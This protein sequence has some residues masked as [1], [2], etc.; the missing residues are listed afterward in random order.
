[1]LSDIE[2]LGIMLGEKHFNPRDRDESLNSNLA[3][4]PESAVSN[5]YRNEG[6]NTHLK[7][8][9]CQFRQ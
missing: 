8:G 6:E 5:D 7:P 1:M 3:R 9:N 2:N 4:T